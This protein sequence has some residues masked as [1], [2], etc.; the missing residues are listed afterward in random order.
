MGPGVECHLT[1]MS[2]NRVVLQA[3]VREFGFRP[4]K[5]YWAS[6]ERKAILDIVSNIPGNEA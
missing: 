2:G 5:C 4:A 3:D 1:F 6:I